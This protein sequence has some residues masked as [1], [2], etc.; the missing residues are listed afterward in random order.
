[1]REGEEAFKKKVAETNYLSDLL[2]EYLPETIQNLCQDRGLS[3]T[4]CYVG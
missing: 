2:V 1:M 4:G 3:L